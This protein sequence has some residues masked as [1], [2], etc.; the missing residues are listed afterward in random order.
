MEPLALTV[1]KSV[2]EMFAS[3][4]KLEIGAVAMYNE[5]AR[6]AADQKDNGSRDLFIKLL[7]DEEKH[8]DWLETQLHQIAEL[9]Y[10]RYL[11]TQTSKGE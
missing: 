1:G 6:I 8:A 9:G 2:K 3:D 10:E 4:L 7:K 5:A 11:T